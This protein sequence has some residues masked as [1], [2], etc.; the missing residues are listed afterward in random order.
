[1]KKLALALMGT[2]LVATAASANPVNFTGPYAGL[3]VGMG[4][5]NGDSS[6]NPNAAA[7]TAGVSS[8]KSSI[9]GRGVMG[10]LELGYQKAFPNNFLLGLGLH[11]DFSNLKN[12]TKVDTFSSKLAL[13]N[14]F[15]GSL[16]LGTVIGSALAYVKVGIESARWKHKGSLLAST[17]TLTKKAKKRL[18]GVVP[19]IGVETKLNDRVNLGV[20][21]RYAMYKKTSQVFTS[22][23]SQVT[24]K[25]KPNVLDARLT[26][27]YQLS[28]FGY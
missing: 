3:S 11:G 9:S 19:A 25:S 22:G 24:V 21:A 5:L 18:I 10:G 26:L 7:V 2:A 13:E 20:E 6:V 23:T 15:G 14:A 12:R 8:G 16:K 17:Y 4:V 28:G 1:M 27:K